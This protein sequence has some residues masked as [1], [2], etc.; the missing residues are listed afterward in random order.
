MKTEHAHHV[1]ARG[2]CDARRLREHRFA[3]TTATIGTV[4]A[5]APATTM[6]RDPMTATT[7]SSTRS[8]R[9]AREQRQ[10]RRRDDHR[11]RRR[12]GCLAIRSAAAPG[13]TVA[14]VAGAVGGAVVGH[15]I[16]QGNADRRRLSCSRPL[17]Q[18]RLPDGDPG[19][20]LAICA[21]ATACASRTGRRFAMDS[22]RRSGRRLR[23][24]RASRDRQ[25]RRQPALERHCRCVRQRHRRRIADILPCP[26]CGGHV[27]L[28]SSPWPVRA[29]RT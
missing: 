24:P 20:A 28:S 4:L 23:S 8:S 11:R 1:V 15:E 27:R 6:V 5:A 7:E 14:T 21:S 19:R 2:H 10:C 12:R 13:N 26:P 17:R 18:R 9:H 3:L 25:H 16:G 29:R 22:L